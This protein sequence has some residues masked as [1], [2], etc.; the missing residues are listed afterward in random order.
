[1]KKFILGIIFLV[2]IFGCDNTIDI[3][4]DSNKTIKI[5]NV[6]EHIQS[7]VEGKKFIDAMDKS[8]ISTTILVGSPYATLFTNRPGFTGY[9]WNNNEILNLSK[10]YPDRFIAFC[11][12]YTKDDMKL[13]K[14][15]ECV[16]KGSKGLKLYSGHTLF[17][18]DALN[19]SSMTEIFEYCE[20]NKIPI[21]FHINP[22]RVNVQAEMEDILKKYPKLVVNCPH[23]C[24]SS[25]N[26]SRFEYLMDSYTLLYTDISFGFFVEDGLKRISRDP[27][28][29][30]RLFEKYPG[31]IMFATDMVV[32]SNRRKTPE[33]MHNL[34]MC[35]RDM[36]EKEE[37]IC[38]VGKEIKGKFK[39][40]NLDKDILQE[41]YEESAEQ[42]LSL[43]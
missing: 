17:Y 16:E 2:L 24:L 12:I 22:A 31:R 36:L 20:A 4:D 19:D 3:S 33:W 7:V 38:N 10:V 32:T 27:E 8:N 42:F 26:S 5:Y 28:K 13:D 29:F 15:K 11:T 40:L 30:I 35:Y 9:D 41:V 14:L 39:G 34:T 37:Y 21:L 23:F 18:E 43:N 6:H 25:I 1:M